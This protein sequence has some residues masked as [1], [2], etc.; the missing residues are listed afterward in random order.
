M[1]YFYFFSEYYEFFFFFFLSLTISIL[2]LFICNL[3]TVKNL[4]SEKTLGYEC[5]FDPFDDARMPFH[6][7]FYLISILFLIFDVEV[8]F[9]FPWAISLRETLFGGFFAMYA[10]ICI[11]TLGFFYEWKKGVLDWD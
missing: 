3:I 11:L 9:F 5:G 1:N 7:K 6:V 4:Y 10:F 2:I 8:A